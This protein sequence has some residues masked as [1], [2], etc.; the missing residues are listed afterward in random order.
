MEKQTT[1]QKIELLNMLS[2][3]KELEGLPFVHS[4]FEDARA[5]LHNGHRL[6]SDSLGAMRVWVRRWN[7]LDQ[8]L[9]AIY[10][11]SIQLGAVAILQGAQ[12]WGDT[13]TE[14]RYNA[15]C[16]AMWKILNGGTP[17]SGSTY[18]VLRSMW[19]EKYGYPPPIEMVPIKGVR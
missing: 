6:P 14:A 3:L 5:A 19:L 7:G 17:P 2:G 16:T 12:K 13:L 15:V 11:P 1:A 18:G 8:R 10:G 4:V 9:R